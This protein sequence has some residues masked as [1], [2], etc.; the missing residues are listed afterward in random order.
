MVLRRVLKSPHVVSRTQ[1]SPDSWLN[2]QRANTLW[3]G[4]YMCINQNHSNDISS[5]AVLLDANDTKT[6]TFR[7][8]LLSATLNEKE[9]DHIHIIV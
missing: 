7:L 9:N 3:F 1:I 6:S 8:D 5:V 2:S 4:F